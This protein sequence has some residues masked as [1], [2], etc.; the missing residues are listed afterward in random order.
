M[1]C[2]HPITSCPLTAHVASWVWFSHWWRRDEWQWMSKF[3]NIGQWC[4]SSNSIVLIVLTDFEANCCISFVLMWMGNQCSHALVFFFSFYD[5]A[6]AL[7]ERRS[8]IRPYG[9]VKAVQDKAAG[10]LQECWLCQKAFGNSLG[11]SCETSKY[12][13]G[14]LCFKFPNTNASVNI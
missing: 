5:T 4:N 9:Q 11:K 3:R 1:L 12:L 10:L 8:P 6:C 7:Q 14:A 2:I 13:T